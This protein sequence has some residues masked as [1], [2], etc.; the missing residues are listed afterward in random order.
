MAKK[1]SINPVVDR[2][3]SSAAETAR[4]VGANRRA[5]DT[6]QQETQT[7]GST[8]GQEGFPKLKFWETVANIYQAFFIHFGRILRLTLIPF[9]I[10][11]ATYIFGDLYLESTY[12][13]QTSFT[14]VSGVVQLIEVLLFY[15]FSLSIFRLM[16]LGNW[17]S[18]VWFDGEWRMR[19]VLYAFRAFTVF[20]P[21][22]VLIVVFI[23]GLRYLAVYSTIGVLTALPFA[24]LILFSI[25][26]RLSF[27]LP[28]AAVDAPYSIF[29]SWRATK[30]MTVKT[31]FIGIFSLGPP[32]LIFVGVVLLLNNALPGLELFDSF[33]VAYT[34]NTS[35]WLITPIG[36]YLSY[37][38]ATFVII[39]IAIMFYFRTGW[40]PGTVRADH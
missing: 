30:G 33:D 2:R 23:V 27:A 29:D 36:M 39:T 6:S 37:V 10:S 21:V 7:D 40:R 15:F 16:L 38:L 20:L 32:L 22:A 4:Y 26:L 5:T 14:L 8:G 24:V 18:M 13:S 31:L 3:R 19:L 11:T 28:A 17:E 9:V 12:V 25:F 1:I 35:Y 34:I